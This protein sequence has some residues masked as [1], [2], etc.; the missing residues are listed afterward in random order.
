MGDADIIKSITLMYP[1]SIIT[2][3]IIIYKDQEIICIFF[4]ISLTVESHLNIFFSM[5]IRLFLMYHDSMIT[6]WNYLDKHAR[7]TII[8]IFIYLFAL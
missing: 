4:F 5:H 2:I 6:L 8:V 1:S 3:K 7:N